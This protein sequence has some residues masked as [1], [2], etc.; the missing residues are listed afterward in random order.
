MA[1]IVP[2][3][4]STVAAY[5]YYC[6]VRHSITARIKLCKNPLRRGKYSKSANS[7]GNLRAKGG[8]VPP[9]ETP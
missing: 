4:K 1:R 7:W 2:V 9:S 3:N 5:I 8:V 6:T